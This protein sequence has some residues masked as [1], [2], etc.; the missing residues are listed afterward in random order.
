MISHENFYLFFIREEKV[1]NDQL[2]TCVPL[3]GKHWVTLEKRIAVCACRGE[4]C[5]CRHCQRQCKI[6]AS[7]VDISIFTH[8]FVFI[9]PKLLKFSEIKGVIFVA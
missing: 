5:H 6:F 7:G 3:L 4:I 1:V 2:V 9:S 8:F